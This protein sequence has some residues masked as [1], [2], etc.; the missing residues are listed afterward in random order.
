MVDPSRQYSELLELNRSWRERWVF[1]VSWALFGSLMAGALA[2]CYLVE[3]SQVPTLGLTS[4]FLVWLLWIPLSLGISQFTGKYPIDRR[5]WKGWLPS[6]FLAGLVTVITLLVLRVTTDRYFHVVDGSPFEGFRLRPFLVQSVVYD[7]FA[8]ISFVALGHASSYYRR[9]T[10]R[11]VRHA[12]MKTRMA[13][14][15]MGFL[16]SQLQP[17]FLLNS[18]NLISGQLYEDVE[19]ADTMIAD[20]GGLLRAT[21]ENPDQHE[22]PLSRELE[23]L[24]LYLDIARTRF[25]PGLEVEKSIDP[26]SLE[27]LV[28]SL[29]LQPLVEN[30]IRHGMNGSRQVS[31]ISI[32]TTRDAYHLRLCVADDGV[33]LTEATVAGRRRKGIGLDNIRRRLEQ[34]YDTDHR[35][36]LANRDGAGVAATIQIPFKPAGAQTALATREALL[37]HSNSDR[38]RRTAGA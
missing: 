1:P 32:S 37:D 12:E 18:L 30:A 19:R 17:H 22:I 21:L 5:N 11:Q 29:L 20:L 10:E 38:R 23:L 36:T 4:W 7:V 14:I 16:K 13:E 25:G 24:E 9:W 33:G 31:R 26:K 8:F 6:Y 27:A 2:F 34:L 15:Q 35:F 3:E 28:P